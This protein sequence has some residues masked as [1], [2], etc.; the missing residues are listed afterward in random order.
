MC[1][2]RGT[3]ASS[4]RGYF[5]GRTVGSS[6]LKHARKK[7]LVHTCPHEKNFHEACPACLGI[8][9]DKSA[10]TSSCANCCLLRG[11]TLESSIRKYLVQQPWLRG[12]HFFFSSEDPAASV[13]NSEESLVSDPIESWADHM[14]LMD[15]L[16]E[17][18]PVPSDS[19]S[20]R[21]LIGHPC[22]HAFPL[23]IPSLS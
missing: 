10:S 4:H 8:V 9:H 22:Q 20:H 6:E 3:I 5:G 11:S 23:A 21:P 7:C 15:E 12:L 19:V 2:C 1:I 16:A 13:S 17:D 18:E 14:E